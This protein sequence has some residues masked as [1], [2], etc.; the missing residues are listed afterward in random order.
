MGSEGRTAENL[1]D[2]DMSKQ[3]IIN[4]IIRAEGGYV[5]NVNDSGGATNYGITEAV[6]RT[7]GYV[8]DM[9]D[10]PWELAYDIYS[11]RYWDSV[12][13]DEMQTLSAVITEE[14]VDTCVNMGPARAGSFLQRALNVM[15][16]QGRLYDDLTVDGAVGPATMRALRSYLT[17][18]DEMTLLVAINALQ[19]AF[20]IELAE[21]REKD[22][23]FVYGWLKHRVKL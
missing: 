19:G 23:E 21:R 18:R 3:T 13:G 6:A 14:V 10:L 2:T 15:N 16:R 22:E 8:G 20:Y 5:D 7:N 9:R 11:G 12:R 17:H 4:R 1:G